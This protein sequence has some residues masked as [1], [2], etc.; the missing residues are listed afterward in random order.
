MK[1]IKKT[2]YL[3]IGM[4]VF[5]II[6]GSCLP[7][8]YI[9]ITTKFLGQSQSFV[10]SDSIT[11]KLLKGNASPN[12]AVFDA[13]KLD[14]QLVQEI[15][16]QHSLDA[17]TI[18]TLN[19]LYEIPRNKKA[20]NDYLAFIDLFEN[21]TV[22]TQINNLKSKYFLFIPGFG[23]K[24]AP[25]TG[26][27]LARQRRLF[28]LLGIEN[29]LIETKEYGLSD[30]NAQ[31]IAN[32]IINASKSKTDIIL[33]SASKGSLE[34][35]ITLGKL[36]S[37]EQL[38]N[39]SAWVSV[40]G[41]LKG[42]PIADKYL[43]PPKRWITQLMLWMKGKNI[44]IVRDISH[45]LRSKLFSSLKIP[46]HIK[47]IHFV[48]MPL[49]SQVHKR[50]KKRF[51]YIQKRFGPNDGLTTITDAITPNGIVVSELGLDHYFKDKNI[52]VKTLALA[53]LLGEKEKDENF[54]NIKSAK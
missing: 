4:I 43:V 45:K 36:L 41:I 26:A 24:S 42:S 9:S 48:G 17:A 40:G 46:L 50:I 21:N 53:C 3:V 1:R 15:S 6:T 14:N 34:T 25:N 18:Y 7:K 47:T 27:D 23:Y 54:Q 39:V 12:F 19:R 8:N 30:I 11:I 20:Q 49:T 10:V 33:V 37:K 28:R 32:E 16:K 44:D 31:I 2:G 38:K 52:D 13:Q 29:K 5:F 35:A 51:C 22:P